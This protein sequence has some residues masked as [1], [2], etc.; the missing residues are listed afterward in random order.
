MFV[1]INA[2]LQAEARTAGIF[3]RNWN[4][5]ENFLGRLSLQDQLKPFLLAAPSEQV[6]AQVNP[7]EVISVNTQRASHLGEI[8]TGLNK[9]LT[10]L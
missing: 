1:C 9:C 2:E 5:K 7:T 8:L 6:S 4:V 10:A 3:I